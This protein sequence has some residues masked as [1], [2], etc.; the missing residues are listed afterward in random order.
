MS[1]VNRQYLVSF[2]PKEDFAR[3][4]SEVS[5]DLFHRRLGH[6]SQNIAQTSTLCDVCEAT[7]ATRQPIPKHSGNKSGRFLELVHSDIEGPLVMRG[8][9]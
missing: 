2:E 5:M 4:A 6:P 3:T 8:R 1:F 7:K 9:V